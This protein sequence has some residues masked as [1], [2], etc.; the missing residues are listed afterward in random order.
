MKKPGL[1]AEERPARPAEQNTRPGR[2]CLVLPVLTLLLIL[3][4]TLTKITNNDIWWQ[5][6]TGELLL[7]EKAFLTADPFSC[8][9]EGMPW[10][11]HEWLSEIIFHLIDRLAGLDGLIVFKCLLALCMGLVV[12]RHAR[13]GAAHPLLTCTV[14]LLALYTVTASLYVRPHLFTY[15]LLPLSIYL[16]ERHRLGGKQ[17]LPLLLIPIMLFW[18]N[19][20]GGFIVGLAAATLYAAGY[21]IAYRIYRN[22]DT[23]RIPPGDLKRTLIV[24]AVLYVTALINPNGYR[25]FLY[26]FELWKS[27]I[28]LQTILEW[29]PTLISSFTGTHT[30]VYYCLYTAAVAVSLFIA[31]RKLHPGPVLIAAF[32]FYLSLSMNRNVGTFAIATAGFVAANFG[33]GRPP[34]SGRKG[35]SVLCGLFGLFILFLGYTSATRGFTVSR[36]LNRQPGFGVNL[37][38]RGTGGARF[39]QEHQLEGRVFN[40][41]AFGGDLIYHCYPRCRPAMDSRNDLYGRTRFLEYSRALTDPGL[42]R[43]YADRYG[44]DIIFLQYPRPGKDYPLHRFLHASPDWHLVYFDDAGLIYLKNEY[45]FRSLIR[46][47]AY[48]HLHP[49]LFA[50]GD[51]PEDRMRAFF[52]EAERAVAASP[53]SQIARSLLVNLLTLS[54]SYGRA[55]AENE[56]LLDMDLYSY[57]YHVNDGLMLFMQG[58]KEEAGRA[59]E[60][61]LSRHPTSVT[62]RKYLE[63]IS[64]E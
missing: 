62:A 12:L 58:R 19:L 7:Q 8:T 60:R 43:A 18:A 64:H 54:G 38:K 32:L 35:L 48:R 29:Q 39:L 27:K 61:A 52:L 34:L 23:R 51:I 6:K 37:Q 22:N 3:P 26:L 36:G 46:E 63:I 14:L 49:V 1:D 42:F 15:L 45:K 5:L 11:N 28:F 44:L 33:A 9:A 56:K 4:L 50:P 25:A 30:F 31:R 20:H 17:R 40:A 21:V 2:V 47:K 24:T 10:I 55:R 53:R 59:F 16:M 13:L 41:Y 57:R